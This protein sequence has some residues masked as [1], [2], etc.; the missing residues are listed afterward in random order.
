M[1]C[2]ILRQPL[3][4]IF[5]LPRPLWFQLYM[6]YLLRKLGGGG[7]GQGRSIEILLAPGNY[8]EVLVQPRWWNVLMFMHMKGITHSNSRTT[9]SLPSLCNYKRIRLHSKC[10]DTPYFEPYPA[11]NNIARMNAC[12]C[13]ITGYFLL[14][15]EKKKARCFCWSVERG[16]KN[17]ETIISISNP[18]SFR[19]LKS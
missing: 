1:S 13:L 17:G 19:V 3:K 4:V 2:P 8:P 6:H 7:A 18:W 10:K 5:T 12:A 9:I 15:E 11:P 14:V 16:E